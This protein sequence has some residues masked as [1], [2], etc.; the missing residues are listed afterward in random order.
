VGIWI[1]RHGALYAARVTPPHGRGTY[2]ATSEPLPA[3]ALI[4][5]LQEL[6]CH[7][8]DIGDA[9]HEADPF[10][11]NRLKESGAEDRA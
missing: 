4:E 6:G 1:V 5:N 10:W 7:Q 8:T 2:W 11:L 3:S 9:F